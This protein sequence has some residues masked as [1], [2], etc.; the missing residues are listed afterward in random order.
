MH[1]HRRTKIQLAIFAVIALVALSFMSLQFMKLPAKMFGVGRYTVTVELPEAAGLYGSSN[2]TYR[3]VEVG[4]VESVHLTDTGVAA[5]LSLKSGIDIPSDLE[6]EV[7]SQSAIGEQYVLLLPRNATSPPLKNGDVIPL[8]DTRVPPNINTILAQV[9]TGLKAVPKDNLK[10]AIDESY[11]A[12]G[13]LGP[14]LSR[15]VKGS[16]DLSIEAR[17]N[18]DPLIALIDQSKPV[19]DSQ[20]NTSDAIQAWASNLATVTSELKTHDQDVAGVLDKGG[21]AF[22]EARQLIERLQPTLPIVLANLVSVGQVALTYQADIEQLLVLLPQVTAEA[23]GT[24]VANQNTKQDYRGEYLSFNLNLNLP[25]PCTTGFLPAQQRRVPTFEDYPDRPAG[26]LYCRAP[27]DSAFNVR[28]ATQHPV[29]NEARQARTH[30]EDV[31]KRR[32]IRAAQRRLQLERR[33]QRHVDRPRHPAAAA[34]VAASSGTG[35]GPAA[36][37]RRPVRPGNRYL[38]R[39]GRKGLHAIRPRPHCT[40]GED[41]ADDADPAGELTM[42]LD[43][44]VVDI[45]DYGAEC[46]ADDADGTPDPPCQRTDVGRAARY[47]ARPGRRRC[48]GCSGGMVG[49]S[50]PPVGARQ[51]PAKSISA[52]GQAG[53]AEPD[54][55]RLAEGRKRCAANPGRCH[56]TVLRRLRQAVTAVR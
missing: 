37:S 27:Q 44:D 2:V 20:T 36:D 6:A 47:A 42:L 53:R 35:S 45:K 4:R 50:C 41:M 49:I 24:F 19:L 15:I 39:A 40:G 31:R 23:G 51:R 38:H 25:P 8:A 28:G 52:G 33:P 13:G 26:D 7:H 34:R 56:G 12:V 9:V 22:G 3:G 1:L 18:L 14:E 43:D 29:R 11:T 46:S 5:V 10:T 30:G 17:K 16:I 21:P 54:H 32:A 55:H 48:I